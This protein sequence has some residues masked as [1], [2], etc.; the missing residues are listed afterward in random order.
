[1]FISSKQKSITKATVMLAYQRALT[2]QAD[3]GYVKGPKQ[4]VPGAGSY[5]YPVFIKLGFI[6]SGV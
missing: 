5:L 6:T 4:L 2:I 3:Q 1:M